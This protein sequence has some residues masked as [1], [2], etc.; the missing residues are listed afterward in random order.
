[1]R[2]RRMLVSVVIAMLAVLAVSGVVL[3][4]VTNYRAHLAG[5]NEVPPVDTRGQGQAIFKLSADGSSMDYK[6]I[7]A[8][9][10]DVTQ[11]HIHCGS[12][13]VNGPVVVFLYGFGPT[14]S[15]NGVLAEGTITQ[16]DVI[17]RP[18]SA[19]CP[20]GVAT[21]AELVSHIEAGNAY[22]NVHT[23]VNPGGEIRGQM[24]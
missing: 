7:A 11:A 1:M 10:K 22:V 18:D 6:L 13:G 5:R 21:L 16:A 20:G 14:V 12:A 23:V 3:A 15:P 2:N 19:A 24:R 4:S 9:I 17:A 8:N